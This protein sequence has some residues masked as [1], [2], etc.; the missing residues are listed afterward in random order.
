LAS[1]SGRSFGVPKASARSKGG[2]GLPLVCVLGP[3]RA[4]HCAADR[5]HGLKAHRVVW[6]A[7]AKIAVEPFA[8]GSRGL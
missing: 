4:L 6:F 7:G 5:R 8:A 2:S 1:N 3:V